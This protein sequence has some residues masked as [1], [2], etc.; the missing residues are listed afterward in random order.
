MEKKSKKT[1]NPLDIALVLGYII[2]VNKG[3]YSNQGF[4]MNK[5]KW[6]K[7]FKEVESWLTHKGYKISQYTDAEDSIQWGNK[8]V[9]INS[10]N[11]PETR[12]YTLLHECGH[13]LISQTARQWS[14]DVPMYASVE[15]ARVERSKAYRVSLVAEEIEAWKRGRRLAKKLNHYIDNDKYDKQITENVF[16]YIEAAAEGV[17]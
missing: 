5:S 8:T 16:S 9:Y 13:L 17:V 3:L 12:Y 7:Q 14:K 2:T 4:R 15:D 6:N 10:R 11:H 1:I